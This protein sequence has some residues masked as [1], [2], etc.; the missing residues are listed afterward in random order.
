MEI[1][2]D[3]FLVFPVRPVREDELIEDNG[4]FYNP[5]LAGPGPVCKLSTTGEHPVSQ[6]SL[7]RA[8]D[9]NLIKPP[10]LAPVYRAKH[11]LYLMGLK[12]GRGSQ[13]FVGRQLGGAGES[14]RS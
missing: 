5:A 2:S 7:P 1:K 11:T 12:R 14:G 9:L 13:G 4:S 8:Q 3:L 10:A 6:T